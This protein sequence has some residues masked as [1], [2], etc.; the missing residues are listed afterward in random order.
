[1]VF[2]QTIQAAK[3]WQDQFNDKPGDKVT[4]VR[5]DTDI[6]WQVSP[7]IAWILSQNQCVRSNQ[8]R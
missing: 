3:K 5:P 6:T 7:N 1:M 2:N 8:K 4:Y